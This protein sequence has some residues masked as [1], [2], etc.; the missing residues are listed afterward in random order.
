M[1]VRKRD[2]GHDDSR[3][4][5]EPDLGN[6][7]ITNLP[8]DV[9]E[10]IAVR[11][12]PCLLLCD[13]AG[14][15]QDRFCHLESA[16]PPDMR[17]AQS[18]DQCLSRPVRDEWIQLIRE[19]ICT[20]KPIE[21]IVIIDGVGFDL[22]S[23]PE[24]SDPKERRVWLSLVRL[25]DRDAS[26]TD[27]GRR[28]LRHH[29]WGGL[30]LLGRAQLETLRLITL[31]LSNQ[32]IADKLHRSKRAVEWHIR[33]LHRLLAVCTREALARVGRLAA[34][35]RFSDDAWVTVVNTRPARR[36]LDEFVLS[37][38]ARQAS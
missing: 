26:E 32:Q 5:L 20:N 25:A 7:L 4:R 12:R 33:H 24:T 30:D 16:M 17:T 23:T 19:T 34:I 3:S 1:E 35:D 31:G 11:S 2:V 36:S 14:R 6:L 10:F 27:R 18:L 28:I 22:V 13:A 38:N 37:G 9:L 21:T 29:E 8:S 15:I